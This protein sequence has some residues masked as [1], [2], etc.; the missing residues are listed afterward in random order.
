MK[1]KKSSSKTNSSKYLIFVCG[2]IP[3]A[4]F[5]FLILKSGLFDDFRNNRTHI[6]N[7]VLYGIIQDA[8]TISIAISSAKLNNKRK[9]NK[10]YNDKATLELLQKLNNEFSS[11]TASIAKLKV[12]DNNTP[13]MKLYNFWKNFYELHPICGRII[14]FMLVTIITALVT[15]I[16]ENMLSNKDCCKCNS[17]N[18]IQYSTEAIVNF[19]Y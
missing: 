1:R 10:L 11:G 5:D 6:Q 15:V 18:H 9:R 2:E 14:G 8:A 13:E 4:K 7:K 16:V 17:C 3:F 19:S 12:T